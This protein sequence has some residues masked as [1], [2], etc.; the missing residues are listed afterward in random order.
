MG[1]ARRVE[2]LQEARQV[3][4][5]EGEGEEG[6]RTPSLTETWVTTAR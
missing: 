5:V 1:Q 4:V 3:T 2:R 6:V